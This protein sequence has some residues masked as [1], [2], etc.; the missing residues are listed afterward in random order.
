MG[1]VGSTASGT[2]ENSAGI[3]DIGIWVGIYDE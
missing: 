2:V 1:F 3:I